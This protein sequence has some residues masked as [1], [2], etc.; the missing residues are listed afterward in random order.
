M[1]LP[2]TSGQ[3]LDVF[4]EYNRAVWPFQIV[5]LLAAIAAL[6]LAAWKRAG[7]GKII[8]SIL[9][10]FW[11]WMGAVYHIGFFS[12]INPAARIFGAAFILEG[13]AIAWAGFRRNPISFGLDMDLRTFIGGALILYA[14][15]IYP[16]I[17]YALG[18]SF[19]YG[20]TFGLPCPTTIFTLGMFLWAGRTLP[21]ALI[22]IPAL[23]SVLGFSAAFALGIREDV[24]LI[25]SALLATTLIL[26]DLHIPGKQWKST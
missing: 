12:A 18:R 13:A 22:V 6:V 14:L 24:G 16:L 7:A 2:F 8:A 5:L 1:D 11:V 4:A 3:F 25:V 19:P 20:P 10:F 23:W 21:R 26:T 17:G 15:L 9:A